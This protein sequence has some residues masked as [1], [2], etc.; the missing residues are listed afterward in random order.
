[1]A[2]S[3]MMQQYLTLKEQNKDA[4]LL[5]RVGDFYEMFFEDAITASKA[6]DLTLTGKDC[7]LEE[8]APMCGVPYHAVDTYIAR[9]VQQGYKAAICDQ[10]SDPATSKGLVDR[11]VTR[12][13]T[14][15][16][17]TQPGL[18]SEKDANYILS[19]QKGRRSCGLAFCDVSTGE[20][21]AYAVETSRLNLSDE[22]SRIMPSEIISSSDT[23]LEDL[24]RSF[25]I[26]FSA[27]DVS[28]FDLSTCKRI[29]KLQFGANMPEDALMTKE[30]TEA[31]GALMKYLNETQRTALNHINQLKL[32]EYRAY[33]MLDRAAAT[34]LE[35]VSSIREKSRRGSLLGV[36]DNPL[37]SMG[38]RQLKEG[39]ERPLLDIKA[40][41][42][43]LNA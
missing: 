5:F 24:C 7:G 8:R 20:F 35:I 21:F 37:T 22:L 25:G 43:R 14:A 2:L 1:M 16:T 29:V 26:A 42:D 15:G 19:I 23:E 39:L 31:A 18:L 34:N 36:T 11:E 10:M 40:I 12:V 9:L 32:Y 13:V 41:N 6:L 17:A 28:E 33:M 3:A 38:A 4:I 30:M 27:R